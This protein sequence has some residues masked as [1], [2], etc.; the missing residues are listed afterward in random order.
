MPSELPTNSQPPEASSGTPK[1]AG[2]R[3]DGSFEIGVVADIPIRIHVTFLLILAW[4]IFGGIQG[5]AW[6]RILWVLTLFACV[7][8]HELGH[9]VTARR[10]G[11]RTRSIVLY[12]I[13]GIASLESQPRPRDEL[14]IALAGPAV[15]LGIALLLLLILSLVGLPSYTQ[16][17]PITA[18][19][20]L[21]A[22][23][24]GNLLLAL[25]NLVPAFPMDGG[26]VLRALL[27]RVTTEASAT[28]IAARIG[29]IIA[30]AFGV[31]AFYQSNLLWLFVAVF[32]Y[33][34][35]SQEA[36]AFHAR[37]LV[38]GHRVRE[39][40][41]KDFRTLTAGTTL[42]AASDLLLAGSQQDFPIVNGEEVV[43]VLT[44]SALMRGIAT[45]GW[46]GYV[47]GIMDR[48]F[49]VAHPDDDLESILNQGAFTGPIMAME[50]D[51]GGNEKLV[52]MLTQEN[53][54]E[55][56]TLAQ[57][58]TRIDARA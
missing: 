24:G 52:G 1:A 36:A 17:A 42:R 10:Y 3:H 32:V 7:V 9:A 53:L 50:T 21:A 6:L 5:Q 4:A 45:N 40:L 15:N 14:W 51:A 25:F 26:R 27:A 19:S 22:L 34:G 2:P 54:L 12:P 33:F 48:D 58:R 16:G 28:A 11:I 18:R 56:L 44:R 20:F 37:T 39:A 43:G 49:A 23:M 47:A 8:L 30:I 41:L 57:L 38:S 55:F 31:F 46:D 29:Q 13:G 35:A